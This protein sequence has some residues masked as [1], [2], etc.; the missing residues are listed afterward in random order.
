[1]EYKLKAYYIWEPGQRKDSE[2]RPH[3][4]DW[5]FPLPE[6]ATDSDRCFVLCDG[7]GGHD[8]GEVASSTVSETLGRSVLQAQA[9]ADGHFD[10]AML[11]QGIE[12]AL[13]ALDACDTGAEQKMG[14]T[15]TFLHLNRK[16]ACLAHIGDSRIY[17]IRPGKTAETTQ[18]LFQTRDHS[19][20]ND[21][22]AMGMLTDEEKEN[23][24]QKNVITRAMQPHLETH[25]K[26]DIHHIDDI[27]A[28]DY[29]YLCSDGMLEN[30]EDPQICYNFS[31]EGGNDE[32]K[33]KHLTMATQENRDNHSA[34]IVH[35]L[36]VSR[37]AACEELPRPTA[38]LMGEVIYDV[39]H[40]TT[41]PDFVLDKEEVKRLAQARIRDDHAQAEAQTEPQT[42][43]GSADA[44]QAG[45]ETPSG[46]CCCHRDGSP[47][48]KRWLIAIFLL[49]LVWCL[50]IAVYLF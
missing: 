32:E 29:F 9:A 31:D 34:I 15:L 46:P 16:G 40:E 18:I 1:M 47:D 28:G 23:F 37:T 14:T 20:F 10:D 38:P 7:M 33:V 50:L 48:V 3:Q 35:I 25:P 43:K 24:T 21:M 45:N 5:M 42:G 44:P 4:E 36:Q 39:E 8:A 11:Q 27:Q 19:L 17:H 26:A 49:V 22:M 13:A 30:M 6:R 41:A 2:G 12:E